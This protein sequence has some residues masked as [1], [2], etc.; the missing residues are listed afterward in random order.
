MMQSAYIEKIGDTIKVR[1]TSGDN[2]HEFSFYA[3][4]LPDPLPVKFED[5]GAVSLGATM[6]VFADTVQVIT[7][8]GGGGGSGPDGGSEHG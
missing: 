6:R 7:G 2:S 5:S 4:A 1:L 8:G 3:S